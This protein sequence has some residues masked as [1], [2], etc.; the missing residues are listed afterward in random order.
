MYTPL[1]MGAQA[2]QA[3]VV[4][5]VVVVVFAPLM[6]TP[7]L[8]LR[9]PRRGVT[10]IAGGAGAVNSDGGAASAQN[11]VAT[12]GFCCDQSQESLVVLIFPK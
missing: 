6:V 1:A 4:V 2:T 7:I 5:V 9:V 8:D 11:A 10:K 12:G 3:Q